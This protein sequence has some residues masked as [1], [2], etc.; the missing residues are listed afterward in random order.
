MNITPKRL[1]DIINAIFDG[2]GQNAEMIAEMIEE[3]GGEYDEILA[4]LL[5]QKMKKIII[6]NI[7]KLI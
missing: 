4:D 1:D 3:D 2:S 5:L 7:T 6:A